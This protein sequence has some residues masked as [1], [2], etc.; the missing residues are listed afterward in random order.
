M[1]RVIERGGVVAGRGR[2]GRERSAATSGERPGGRHRVEVRAA[3]VERIRREISNG[4]YDTPGR[5]D[6]AADRLLDRL[7]LPGR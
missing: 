4:T 5:L 3:L 1:H 7:G 6:A 2:A